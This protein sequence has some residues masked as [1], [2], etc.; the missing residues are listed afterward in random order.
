[1]VCSST[2]C[3]KIA[4]IVLQPIANR[5]EENVENISEIFQ[6][7][8]RRT[9]VLMGF[10]IFYQVVLVNPK[11]RILVQWKSLRNNLEILCHPICNRVQR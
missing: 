5:V 6:F 9:R 4:Q 3:I 11:G 8:T 1:M 7:G 10:I 2:L